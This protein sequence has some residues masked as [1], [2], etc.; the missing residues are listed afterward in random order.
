MKQENF[1]KLKKKV[2]SC[3][4]GMTSGC[5]D[6]SILDVK[7]IASSS[8]LPPHQLLY[9]VL[10]DLLG[11]KNLG[12]WEKVD[13]TVPFTYKNKPYYFEHAKFGMGIWTASEY[14]K[15]NDLCEILKITNDAVSRATPFF[16]SLANTAI[17]NSK[18]N[19]D[20]K[21]M[22]LFN[23]YA[24]F[25]HK[26]KQAILAIPREEKKEIE[27]LQKAL[28][29]IFN[30]IDT[31]SPKKKVSKSK[32]KKISMENIYEYYSVVIHAEWLENA[33][34]E[35][36]FS[37]TEHIFVLLPIILG[38]ISTGKEILSL[39]LNNNWSEKYKFILPLDD[40][41]SKVLYDKLIYIREHYRNHIAHGSFGKE[42][43]AFS[44]HSTAGA[45]PFPP[46]KSKQKDGHITFCWDKIKT[47]KKVD[48]V[49]IFEDFVT[50]LWSGKRAPAG[51]YIQEHGLPIYMNRVVNKEYAQAMKSKKS[52]RSFADYL[53]ELQERYWNMDW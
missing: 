1:E 12:R 36:F 51:I 23:K 38:K 7:K 15:D 34:I 11:Y 26:Y 8:D 9:F 3:F 52:M 33:M 25:A 47:N 28:E 41:K 53:S 48:V 31:G 46:I 22:K 50:H 29:K 13:W 24:Y 30:S 16:D 32:G 14:E 39:I 4:K 37:W 43:D 27:Q 5:A 10:V 17:K 19:I 49:N 45:T 35:A 42:L 21:A 18:L 2:S 6:I 40:K 20:N 44:F